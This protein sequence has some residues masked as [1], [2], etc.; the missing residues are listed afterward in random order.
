MSSKASLSAGPSEIRV[1]LLLCSASITLAYLSFHWIDTGTRD[2]NCVQENHL[3]CRD[4]V[5]RKE[6]NVHQFF[7]EEVVLTASR[8]VSITVDLRPDTTGTSY[9]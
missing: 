8:I 3:P 7:I 5:V 4:L 9:R 6:F 1:Y 2:S